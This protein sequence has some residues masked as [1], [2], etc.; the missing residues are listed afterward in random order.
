M[1]ASTRRLIIAAAAAFAVALVLVLA[2]H[3]SAPLPQ[4]VQTLT[5]VFR[6]AE[7]SRVRRGT[8]TFEQDGRVLYYAE[9]NV[10]NLRRYEGK[11]VVAS[12][13]LE[14]NTDSRSLPVLITTCGLAPLPCMRSPRIAFIMI[15]TGSGITAMATSETKVSIR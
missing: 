14:A 3:R 11:E 2:L 9:S 8:H 7:L 4:G 1:P 12:G 10:V 15:G 5:G 6:P 13:T